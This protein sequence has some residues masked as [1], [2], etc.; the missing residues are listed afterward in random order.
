MVCL[1]K[2]CAAVDWASCPQLSCRFSRRSDNCLVVGS[3]GA[4]KHHPQ[5]SDCFH[6]FRNVG[7]EVPRRGGINAGCLATVWVG[8]PEEDA[9]EMRTPGPTPDGVP[10]PTYTLQS[11]LE[12]ESVLEAIG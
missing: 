8:P 4:G 1:S 6:V 2:C 11:V 12:L 5:H 10:A 3:G 7:E 9:A